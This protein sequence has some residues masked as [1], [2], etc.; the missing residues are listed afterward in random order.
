VGDL[1]GKVGAI[2]VVDGAASSSH[3]GDPLPAINANF[4]DGTSVNTEA[5]FASIVFHN[6]DGSRFL[7]GKLTKV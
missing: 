3:Q 5:E 6:P 2:N 1:S 7:C 4:I